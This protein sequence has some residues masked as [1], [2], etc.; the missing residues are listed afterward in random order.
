MKSATRFKQ[1]LQAGESLVGH[2]IIEF[3]GRGTA[4]MLEA[5]G[6]D[7]AMIDLEHSALTIERVADLVAWF[8]ATRVAPLVRVPQVQWVSRVLD[9]G[10]VGIMAPDVR[11]AAQAAALVHA[12]KYAPLG[13]RGAI[14]GGANTNYESVPAPVFMAGANASTTLICQIESR[15]GVDNCDAI[16]STPGVDV[17]WIGHF[18]LSISLGI[19]GEFESPEFAAAF[20]HVADVARRHRQ[21]LGV[22]PGNAA[23]AQLFAS[24]GAT[25]FS[26]S[27][28]FAVYQDALGKG[29]SDLRGIL[30]GRH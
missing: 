2:M 22:Q 29:I 20:R 1:R 3:S 28:D 21:V 16:A 17:L 30:G 11:D 19:P 27:A 8:R 9:A 14:F 26:Y 23:Q 5:A 12:M 4:R 18:D 7:F 24:Y 10:A 25:L 15:S 6:A 13:G